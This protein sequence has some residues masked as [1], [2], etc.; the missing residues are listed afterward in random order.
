[1]L[2]VFFSYTNYRR[3]KKGMKNNLFNGMPTT[4]TVYFMLRRDTGT[5]YLYFSANF[6]NGK[7]FLAEYEYV[8]R[9]KKN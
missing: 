8:C 7:F 6:K 9:W 1:M 4:V 5:F 3:K 2:S